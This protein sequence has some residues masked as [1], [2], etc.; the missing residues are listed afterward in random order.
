MKREV[1]GIIEISTGRVVAYSY[2]S[3]SAA[4]TA[5]RQTIRYSEHRKYGVGPIVITGTVSAVLDE[6]DRW[7]S[8]NESEAVAE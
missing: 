8:V 3:E 4:K 5:L 7:I 2:W 1:Y 6:N